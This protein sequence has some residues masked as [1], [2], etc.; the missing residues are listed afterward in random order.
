MKQSW[1]AQE[2][3]FVAI[4]VPIIDLKKGHLTFMKRPAGKTPNGSLIRDVHQT[5]PEPQRQKNGSDI[6]EE[7]RESLYYR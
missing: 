7:L 5:P 1:R 6:A 2:V 4:E 3:V